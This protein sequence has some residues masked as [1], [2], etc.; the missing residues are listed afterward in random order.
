MEIKEIEKRILEFVKDISEKKGYTPTP[1]LSFIHLTEEVGEIARQLSNKKMKTEA[2]DEEN[3]KEEII[4]TLL[5][6]IILAKICK[7]DIEKELH[8]KLEKLKKRQFQ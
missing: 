2:F 3:L 5:E 7:V 4:D 6:N 8:K 1:E